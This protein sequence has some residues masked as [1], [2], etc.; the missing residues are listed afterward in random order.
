MVERRLQIRIISCRPEARAASAFLSKNPSTNGPFQMERAIAALRLFL[1]RVTACDDEFGAG[2]VPTRLF[3]LRRKAPRRDGMTPTGGAP[4]ATAMGV[5]YRVHGNA[6]VMRHAAHP[7]FAAS[8]A[9]GNIHVIGVGNRANRGHAPPVHEALLGRVEP[10][11]HVS[12]VAA[13]DLC[14]APR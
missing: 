2:L 5:I 9:D 8:L 7:P 12:A 1:P 3:A 13:Y 6:A 10:Q 4:L 14:V 11:D